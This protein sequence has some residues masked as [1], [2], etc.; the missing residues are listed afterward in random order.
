MNRQEIKT[1]ST[2]YVV[3]VLSSKYYGVDMRST[4]RI[5][6]KEALTRVPKMPP[7]FKGTLSLRGKH[8]SVFDI[9]SR[10]GLKTTRQT[11]ESRIIVVNTAGKDVGFVVDA[12]TGVLPVLNS[13]IEPV[14]TYDNHSDYLS[15]ITTLG[16]R[17]V[18]LIDL[19]RMFSIFN[20]HIPAMQT[21]NMPAP[22][23]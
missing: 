20:S 22:V 3:F 16:S 13:S 5:L 1:Y 17:Q 21:D 18:L 23:R 4:C 6:P 2:L 19:D 7:L 9:R 14:S 12:V 11:A 10:L 15:G 8:V